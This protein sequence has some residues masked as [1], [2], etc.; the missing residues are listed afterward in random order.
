MGLRSE[1][2][3]HRLSSPAT[4]PE[5]N[6]RWLR[7]LLAHSASPL[8]CAHCPVAE[9]ERTLTG[10]DECDANDPELP[11]LLNTKSLD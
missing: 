1:L 10:A 4:Q 3:D 2:R 7:L 9:V 11:K 6:D 8:R 5:Q